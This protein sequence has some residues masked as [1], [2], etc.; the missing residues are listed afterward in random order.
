MT[1]KIFQS[2]FAIAV[3]GAACMSLAAPANDDMMDAVEV[4][5]ESGEISGSTDG[6]TFETFEAEHRPGWGDFGSIWYKWTAPLSGTFRFETVGSTETSGGPLDTYLVVWE[7]SGDTPTFVKEDDDGMADCAAGLTVSVEQGVTYLLSISSYESYGTARLAWRQIHFPVSTFDMDGN[8]AVVVGVLGANASDFT[9]RDGFGNDRCLVDSRIVDAEKTSGWN[10]DT[11]WCTAL[12]EMDMLVWTGWAQD[13]GYSDVDSLADYFRGN[14]ELLRTKPASW[15]QGPAEGT[16]EGSA[17]EWFAD[18]HD[19]FPSRVYYFGVDSLIGTLDDGLARISV[20]CDC[21]SNPWA[22]ISGLV[23]HT[24]VC[25]GYAYDEF[26]PVGAKSALKGLFLIDPDNDQ[27]TNGGAGRAPN[28]ISYRPVVW[29]EAQSRYDVANVWGGR[30][31]YVENLV[32]VLRV[33]SGYTPVCVDLR[34]GS[35][36]QP[37]PQPPQPDPQPRELAFGA[38][39]VSTFETDDGMA[40]VAGV[41]NL[42]WEKFSDYDHFGTTC[43]VD[44]RIVDAEKDAARNND[45]FWCGALTDIDM[46]FALG[47]LSGF[48]TVDEVVGRFQKNGENDIRWADDPATFDPTRG[49]SFDTLH[50]GRYG[51]RN[52]AHYTGMFRWAQDVAGA[53]GISNH[54]AAGAVDSGFLTVLR[55]SFPN[56]LLHLGIEFPE[57]NS[58]PFWSGCDGGVLHSVLCCGYV[59][60][61]SSGADALKGLFIIDPDNDQYAA[62]GG[63]S[64]MN[65][66]AYCPVVWNSSSSSYQIRGVWGEA[67]TINRQYVALE[68]PQAAQVADP[69]LDP[70][71]NMTFTA[72]LEV[73]CTCPTGDATIRFTTND[74]EVTESSPTWANLALTATTVVR[75]RAYKPGLKASNEVKFTY[76]CEGSEDDDRDP[77]LWTDPVVE[78]KDELEATAATSYTGW[79]HD[80]KGNLTGSF[81]LKVNKANKTGLAKATLTVTDLA[82]GRKTKYTGNYNVEDGAFEDGQLEDL[83]IGADGVAGKIDKEALTGGRTVDKQEAQSVDSVYKNRIFAFAFQ[84]TSGKSVKGAATF[85]AKFSSKGKAKVSGTLMDGTKVSATAQLIV[86]DK[87]CALPVTFSKKGKANFGLVLW[88]NEKKATFKEATGLTECTLGDGV[89]DVKVEFVGCGEV[90]GSLPKAKSLEVDGKKVADIAANG[91]KWAATAAKGY[92]EAKPKVTYAAKKGTLTGS[93]KATVKGSDKPVSAKI[94]GVWLG[95]TGVGTAVMKV[96]KVTTALPVLIK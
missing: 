7:A 1:S 52:E 87:G 68:R 81:T 24:L 37:D 91:A 77:S 95:K 73:K 47:W 25:C 88:F 27:E 92:E 45:D 51:Y 66:I 5:G 64:A 60:S 36:P 82:T 96:N 55:N 13:E 70:P 12:S 32:Q 86:G 15:G 28:S 48:Q 35:D 69:V 9:S 89:T 85:T 57:T 3:A 62:G 50:E 78:I 40:T 59:S 19:D 31:G 94:T 23:G 26:A 4:S 44:A 17:L 16:Y 54:V 71:S 41:A 76:T 61:G 10:D 84:N 58:H 22:G 53:S 18:R 65:S 79:L 34:G 11:Y 90:D 6:A 21:S 20:V 2:L 14:P 38:G 93:Y 33:R 80:A 42:T 67:G 30:D 56:K 74:T 72:S 49:S 63:A 46:M 75:V 83:E 8:K 39:Q 29:N 43:F